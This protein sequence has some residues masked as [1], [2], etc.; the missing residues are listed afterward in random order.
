MPAI[1]RKQFMQGALGT[2]LASQFVAKPARA[3]L[4]S[5]PNVLFVIAD[6]WRAQSFGYA[7]DPNAHTPAIDKF[8]SESINFDNAVAGTPVCCP[9]RACLMTGQYPLTNGVYINDVPLVP[10]GVTLGEAFANAGYDTGYI[11]KWHLYGSPDGRFG[12]RLSYIPPDKRFG[13]EYWKACECTHDYNHSLYYEGDD[14]TPKFWDGYDAIAQTKDA[15][16]FMR[17]FKDA[18]V[19]F[20]MFL[21]WGPPHF[22]LAGAPKRYQDMFKDRD[23]QLRPNVPDA[24]REKAI[25]DLR[26]YYAHG[27]ALNDCFQSLLDTLEETGMADNTIVV[28]TSDH[29]DMMHSQGLEYKWVP[30]EESVRI[31]LLIR[32]PKS[33]GRKGMRSHAPVASPDIMPTLLGLSGLDVP[34]GVQGT[35]LSGSLKAPSIKKSPDSA[36]LCMPVPTTSA[37]IYGI[38]AYRGVRTERY[39]YVRSLHGPWLLYDNVN[40]PYQK[41]NLCGQ[42]AMKTVQHE[43]NRELNRWLHKLGDKFLPPEEYLKRDGLTNY[44]ATKIP[45][46]NVVSPWGDWKSTLKKPAVQKPWL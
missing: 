5:R 21:S 27:A 6:E 32:Y 13:F 44:I 41:H 15:C 1:T 28:F 10:K 9:S 22:P 4:L 3:Q 24:D 31:P 20:F 11:G 29:G 40:D 30:W 8:A 33:F 35:D 23:I 42:A 18:H 37:R 14:P 36:F 25:E 12:R 46:G 7:G 45:I 43:L 26:G 38:D 16:G 19:P 2:L 34:K 39:T 17:K